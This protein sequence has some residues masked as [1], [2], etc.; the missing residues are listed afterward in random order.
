M[1]LRAL[2]VKWWYSQSEP[3]IFSVFVLF[4]FCQFVLFTADVRYD[5]CCHVSVLWWVVLICILVTLLTVWLK[6]EQLLL[7]RICK[8][9]VL[10]G[11][12]NKLVKTWLKLEEDSMKLQCFF[13]E[14]L[15][16]DSQKGLLETPNCCKLPDYW[17]TRTGERANQLIHLMSLKD[18]SYT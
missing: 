4:T 5:A 17:T 14:Q 10:Y 9:K 7:C 6:E 1:V 16:A 18:V 13:H 8:G 15:Q 2:N 3:F 11:I 12:V